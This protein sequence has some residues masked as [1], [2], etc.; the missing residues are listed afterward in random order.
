[1]LKFVKRLVRGQ[2]SVAFQANTILIMLLTVTAGF[3]IKFSWS[4]LGLTLLMYC[5]TIGLGVSVTYHRYL[6]HR[7]FHMHP[8]LEKIGKFFGAM[9]GTGSPIMWVLTHR[10]HHAN[11]DT[12][13]DPHPPR[14]ILQTLFGKYQKVDLHGIANLVRNPSNKFLH[15]YY[16]AI[17]FVYGVCWLLA[18]AEYFYYGFVFPIFVA[19]LASNLLNLMGHTVALLGYRSHNTN[20][21]S[22]N[23]ALM[24]YLGFGEGWHNNHH[25]YPGSARFGL[26]PWEFDLGFLFIKLASVFGLVTNIKT[27]K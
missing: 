24:G 23:N 22:S 1:M 16:F 7:S 17:L 20:D 19:V 8:V 13:Q 18:G 15:E 2:N 4:M 12:D 21:T 9:S 14:K 10:M 6:T 5:L 27:P 3:W 11:S 26:K 25:R